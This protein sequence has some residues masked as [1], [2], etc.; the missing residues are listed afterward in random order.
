MLEKGASAR[1]ETGCHGV[2]RWPPILLLSVINIHNFHHKQI[3]LSNVLFAYEMMPF[4][5][6]HEAMDRHG[7]GLLATSGFLTRYAFNSNV[8]QLIEWVWFWYNAIRISPMAIM[9]PD[10]DFVSTWNMWFADSRLF[11]AGFEDSWI[12]LCKRKLDILKDPR[13]FA[14]KQTSSA[15]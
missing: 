12:A 14:Q 1:F 11:Y 6:T 4:K 2:C 13:G 5:M 15:I 9:I 3:W 7:K 10:V 8:E